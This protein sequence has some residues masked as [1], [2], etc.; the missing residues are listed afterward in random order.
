VPTYTWKDRDS[1]LYVD[2]L[3]SFDEIE[4][5]PTPDEV[6]AAGGDTELQRRWERVITSVRPHRRAP[7]YGMKGHW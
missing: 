5:T 2:V 6:A 1:D 7:G 3:R 4:V